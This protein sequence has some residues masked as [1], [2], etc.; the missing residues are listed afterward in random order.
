M[1]GNVAVQAQPAMRGWL[2]RLRPRQQTEMVG[3]LFILPYLI[4]FVLF[5]LIP[6][7]W[8]FYI[9]LTSWGGLSAPRFVGFNK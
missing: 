3:Y 9:S 7:V 2:A 5:M 1:A 8:G 4:A 6:T